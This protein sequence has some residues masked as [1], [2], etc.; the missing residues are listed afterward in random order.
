MGGAKASSSATQPVRTQ[1]FFVMS[2]RRGHRS[3]HGG[4]ARYQLPY[5]IDQA[6]QGRYRE[7]ERLE[8]DRYAARLT[9]LNRHRMIEGLPRLSEAE[10][11][12]EREDHYSRL[13]KIAV[14]HGEA[15][16]QAIEVDRAR[17]FERM[18]I[19]E[20]NRQQQDVERAR[21]ALEYQHEREEQERRRELAATPMETSTV[22]TVPNPHGKSRQ[23]KRAQK[24]AA[25]QKRKQDQER[26][27]LD[28]Q[29]RGKEI[30][31]SPFGNMRGRVDARGPYRTGEPAN[32]TGVIPP[33]AASGLMPKVM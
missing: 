3:R 24:L 12:Q 18:Q 6:L 17:N 22:E 16:R 13:R 31:Q 25:E 33:E 21:R 4:S 5:P 30:K 10:L 11:A 1:S 23:S 20:H 27:R 7:Q 19:E 9:E 26:Q 14:E 28:E 15:R 32:N 8:N 2:S 29:K